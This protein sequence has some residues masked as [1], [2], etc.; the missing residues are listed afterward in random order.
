MGGRRPEEIPVIRDEATKVLLALDN[1]IG[2]GWFRHAK[3]ADATDDFLHAPIADGMFS[4]KIDGFSH[5]ARM[6][7]PFILK[8]LQEQN[9][10][11]NITA[12]TAWNESV[13][14]AI[15]YSQWQ[16]DFHWKIDT[17]VWQYLLYMKFMR[18]AYQDAVNGSEWEAEE[19]AEFLDAAERFWDEV[20]VASDPKPR[21]VP[22]PDEA[23][24]I[25]PVMKGTTSNMECTEPLRMRGGGS[26]SDVQTLRTVATPTQRSTDVG[27]V[28]DP[29]T[30]RGYRIDRA[31]HPR[32]AP[33]LRPT[34]TAAGTRELVR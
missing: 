25:H 11:L 26:G 12:V 6:T 19:K 21:A 16:V 20:E 4:T 29:G 30:T 17:R 9:F 3:L 13:N 8:Y 5:A 23:S 18:R 33:V 28:D 15:R 27:G 34:A 31:F 1:E 14:S 22:R 10:R 2:Q 24:G 32:R 7:T